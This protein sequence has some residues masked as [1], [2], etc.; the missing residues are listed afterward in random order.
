VSETD[1]ECAGNSPA[2]RWERAHRANGVQVRTG[3]DR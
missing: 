2:G 1:E 3:E